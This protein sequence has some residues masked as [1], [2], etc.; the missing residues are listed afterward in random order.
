MNKLTFLFFLL[1]LY[2]IIIKNLYKTVESID[3]TVIVKM[4]DIKSI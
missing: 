2:N 3:V 1:C 4:I